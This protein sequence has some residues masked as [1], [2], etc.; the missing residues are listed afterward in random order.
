M[1]VCQTPVAF[2][3]IAIAIIASTVSGQ[4]RV[5]VLEEPD[6]ERLPE[7]ERLE[8]RDPGRD[9]DQHEH[10]R[11]P[12]PVGPEQ[13]EDPA[14]V[15][16]AR[17]VHQRRRLARRARAAIASRRCRR[18]RATRQTRDSQNS[19]ASMMTAPHVSP[20]DE[21][22]SRYRMRCAWRRGHSQ[23]RCAD[24]RPGPRADPAGA[25]RRPRAAG[26]RA[27]RRGRRRRVHR[28]RPPRQARQGRDAPGRAPRPPPLLP[29]LRSGGRRADR[30]ARPDLAP[31]P[32]PLA[33]AGKQ[34]ARGPLR[35]HAAT[36]TSPECSAHS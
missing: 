32:G 24:R 16:L 2:V 4:H 27:R 26:E 23:H 35:P 3:K 36:T 11:E 1:Y 20:R 17:R 28:Q 30:S 6:V 33:Q 7:Q 12:Q 9:H 21:M 25:R 22:W 13:R 8:H 34:G 31:R 19:S 5:V 14:G 18:R 15:A 10:G 29:H